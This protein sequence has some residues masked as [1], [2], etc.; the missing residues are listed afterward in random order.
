M[1]LLTAGENG[2]AIVDELGDCAIVPSVNTAATEPG[3]T[4]RLL[5]GLCKSSFAG[6]STWTSL[7]SG[8]GPDV[9]LGDGSAGVDGDHGGAGGCMG[10]CDDTNETSGAGASGSSSIWGSGGFGILASSA[11]PMSTSAVGV[12]VDSFAGVSSL[13]L[14][15][16]TDSA[17]MSIAEASSRGGDGGSGEGLFEETSLRVGDLLSILTDV[18]RNRSRCSLSS[19]ACCSSLRLNDNGGFISRGLIQGCVCAP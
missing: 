16:G 11:S 10:G 6:N 15:S 7:E 5:V 9:D 4:T 3:V 1:A 18:D 13:C 8:G 17:E 2:D 14:E 19:C 12:G